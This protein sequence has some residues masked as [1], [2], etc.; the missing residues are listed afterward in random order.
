V[1][2]YTQEEVTMIGTAL[3]ESLVQAVALSHRIKGYSRVSLLLLA[4][5]ESGKT[6]IATAATC[7]HVARVA[8]ISGR[9][10]LKEMAD[11]PKTEFLLFNDLSAVKAMSFTAVNLLIVLLNQLTPDRSASSAACRSTRSSIIVRAGEH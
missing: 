8:M 7:E 6:T 4:A 2:S 10:V 1:L 9:S 11:H 5:P 3:V